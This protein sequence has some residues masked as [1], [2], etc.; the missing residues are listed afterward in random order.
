MLEPEVVEV[1]TEAVEPVVSDETVADV[2]EDD[3]SDED[4]E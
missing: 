2:S 1:Q 4:S 3:E